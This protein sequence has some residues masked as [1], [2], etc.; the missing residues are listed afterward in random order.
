VKTYD[1]TANSIVA[2]KV[3]NRQNVRNRRRGIGTLATLG[4]GH[5]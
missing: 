5:C 2:M 3:Q 4:T 1:I